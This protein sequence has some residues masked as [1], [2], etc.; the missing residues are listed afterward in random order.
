TVRL[1]SDA[2]V[3][4]LDPN[5]A[6][7][8][9]FLSESN[10]KA[11]H[12]REKQP[13]PDHP[14]RFDWEPQVLSRESLT[15]RCY[16]EAEWSG[17]MGVGIVVTYKGMRSKGVDNDFLFGRNTRSWQLKC[18]GFGYIAWYNGHPTSIS[19]PSSSRRVGVY[20]D[21][22]AGTLSFYSVSDTHTHLHTFNSTFSEPLYAGFLIPTSCSV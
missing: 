13:Y 12:V 4:T 9:L 7:P 19:Y 10:R 18:S 15:G 8:N 17:P 11:T 20:L 22:P 6:H 5:T 21:V 14:Q 1:C 3:L 2:C 16:W